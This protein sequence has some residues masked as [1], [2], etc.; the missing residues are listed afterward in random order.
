MPLEAR[1]PRAMSAALLIATHL[2][3]PYGKVVAVTDVERSLMAGH[4]EAHTVEAYG[5][6]A[7]MFVECE[8]SLIERAGS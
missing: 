1:L 7:W 3:A 4:F 8:K 6:L 5:I 2:N